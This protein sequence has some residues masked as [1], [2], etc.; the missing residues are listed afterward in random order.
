MDKINSFCIV[1][2]GPKSGDKYVSKNPGNIYTREEAEQRAK[3]VAAECKHPMLVLE[4]VAGFGPT[5]PPVK[6]IK[7][8]KPRKTRSKK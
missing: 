4:V 3:E 2:R 6:P 5:E 1:V 7:V 8:V